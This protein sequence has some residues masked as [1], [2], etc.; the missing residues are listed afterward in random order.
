MKKQNNKYSKIEV[1]KNEYRKLSTEQIYR[2]LSM[3][4]TIKEASIAYHEI[5]KERGADVN[6]T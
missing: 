1:L 4:I 6:E 3:D 2:K 5:L